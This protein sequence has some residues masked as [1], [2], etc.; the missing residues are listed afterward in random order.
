MTAPLPSSPLRTRTDTALTRNRGWNQ[1]SRPP[2]TRHRP[3]AEPA[4]PL[5]LSMLETEVQRLGYPGSGSTVSKRLSAVKAARLSSESGP[6]GQLIQAQLPLDPRPAGVVL[7]GHREGVLGAVGPG[8][9][10]E[11]GEEAVTLEHLAPV[12][13]PG[14]EHLLP[15]GGEQLVDLASGLALF[16]A[17]APSSGVS[18]LRSARIRSSR[19]SMARMLPL[20]PDGQV[21]I[22]DIA[23]TSS[24]SGSP[25]RAKPEGGPG[26]DTPVGNCHASG[27]D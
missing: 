15:A 5:R 7:A 24:G 8:A 27:L 17:P 2:L 19:T 14:L 1:R 23:C 4:V 11:Q 20:S 6:A 18:S 22:P 25:R 26:G 21:M 12:V 16:A 10:L 9:D 3:P 13:G